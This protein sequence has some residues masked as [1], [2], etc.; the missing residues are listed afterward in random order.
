MFLKKWGIQHRHHRKDRFVTSAS[1]P[2]ALPVA[3]FGFPKTRRLL[4]RAE[5]LRVQQNGQ[6]MDAGPL[7][8]FFLPSDQPL[9]IGITTSR[10]VGDA[11]FRNRMRRLVREAAR[12][13][14]IPQV[15]DFC[16]DIV[17][18][19]KKDLP[20]T[21]HQDAVDRAMVSLH[22]RLQRV[23]SQNHQRS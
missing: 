5:F 3:M 22:K 7:L 14:L 13:I 19:A 2:P 20:D 11:V 12:R 17:V 18:V 9:R 16:F 1:S 23:A 15:G 10:K 6:R 21:I 8:V 4:K